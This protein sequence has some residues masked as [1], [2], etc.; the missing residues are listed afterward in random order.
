MR[1]YNDYARNVNVRIFHAT[2]GAP[3]VDVYINDRL[4]I[5]GLQYK[6]ASQYLPIPKGQYNVKLYKTDTKQLLLSQELLINDHNFIT[7]AA[8]NNNGGV[9]LLVFEDKFDSP[10]AMM[11]GMMPQVGLLPQ[12]PLFNPEQFNFDLEEEFPNEDYFSDMGRR[13]VEEELIEETA[14]VRFIHL[15]PNAPGVD[16]VLA[17][18]TPLVTD[19]IYKEASDYIEVAPGSYTIQIR[20]TGTNTPVL[21]IPNVFLQA[22]EYKTAYVVGLVNGTP[23]LE[24]IILVDGL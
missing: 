10:L 11:D 16:V 15:S 20:P 17:N 1:F 18:G 6:E 24:T 3:I 12:T 23:R 8:A 13:M 7:I 19:L 9:Q 2:A 4:V 22:N 14:K 21:T 5:K